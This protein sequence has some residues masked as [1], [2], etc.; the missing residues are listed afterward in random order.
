MLS[1]LYAYVLIVMPVM[2]VDNANSQIL[3]AALQVCSAEATG[4]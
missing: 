1:A 2:H 3:L 4:H